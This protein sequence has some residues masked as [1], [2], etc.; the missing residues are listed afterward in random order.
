MRDRFDLY[1][2][3]YLF[4]VRYHSGKWSRGYKLLC[5]LELAGYQPGLG[6]RERPV[7]FESENQREIYKKLVKYYRSK[8]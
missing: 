2:A 4:C 1:G 6:L 5:R 7:N 3:L 8:V